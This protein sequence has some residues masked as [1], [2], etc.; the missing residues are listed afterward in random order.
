MIHV[1]LQDPSNGFQRQ[2]L[3][4]SLGKINLYLNLLHDASQVSLLGQVGGR[5]QSLDCSGSK[6]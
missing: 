1:Y 6:E 3:G 5:L 4:D 2:E